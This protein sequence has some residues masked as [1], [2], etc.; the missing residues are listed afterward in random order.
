[1]IGGP[2]K[3]GQPENIRFADKA[4]EWSHVGAIN[5]DS[6]GTR[7]LETCFLLAQLASR[8]NDHAMS[9]LRS[10][11]HELTHVNERSRYRVIIR[12]RVGCSKVSR[13]RRG[14]CR[15][16]RPRRQR[17]RRRRADEMSDK[18]TPPHIK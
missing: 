3:E 9:A 4:G 11:A 6:S 14:L 12:L 13:F 7:L 8:I 2:E 15:I 10:V 18:F 17:P 1:M 5:V 16:L